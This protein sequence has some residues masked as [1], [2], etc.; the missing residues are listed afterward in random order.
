MAK[1]K[2]D[3]SAEETAKHSQS[4]KYRPHGQRDQETCAQ[5]RTIIF[6][7]ICYDRVARRTDFLSRDH[8]DDESFFPP[9]N[10][11]M[12]FSDGQWY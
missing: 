7:C 5:K 10:A 9:I 6:I 1:Q 4:E 3:S 11:A 8:D 2:R 12:G